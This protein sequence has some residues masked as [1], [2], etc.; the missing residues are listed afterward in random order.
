[1]KQATAQVP[2]FLF[3]SFAGFSSSEDEEV[4]DKVPP[5]PPPPVLHGNTDTGST[6]PQ[7]ASLR[8]RKGGNRG[9][10]RT[11]VLIPSGCSVVYT[12]EGLPSYVCSCNVSFT[13]K[14]NLLRHNALC[15]HNER[16]SDLP[17]FKKR[18]IEDG[19]HFEVV[20][21]VQEDSIHEAYFN[22]DTDGSKLLDCKSS[23]FFLNF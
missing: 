20:D 23:S 14:K 11:S 4:L 16:A 8:K 9:G 21:N 3:M 13:E 5:V 19:E 22:E 18:R 7:E 12:D 10:G 6:M 1:M 2:I 15:D 17:T